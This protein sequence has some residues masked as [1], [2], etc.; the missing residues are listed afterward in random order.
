VR[1]LVRD[2]NHL[3]RDRTALHGRDCEGEGFAW[4][5][6]DDHKNSVFACTRRTPG[7]NPILVVSNFTPVVRHAYEV[8]VPANG[9][10]RELI[11]SDA[12]I[13]GGSGQG[14]LGGVEAREGR[15]RLTLPPLATIMLEYE[16]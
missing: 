4:A 1:S 7:A 12:V 2:L 3:Y 13:Y 11:N 8:P 15:V 16:P 9:R 10:W 6:A 5:I 14:N